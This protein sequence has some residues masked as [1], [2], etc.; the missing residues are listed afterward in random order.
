M[1]DIS[2]FLLKLYFPKYHRVVR[3]NPSR[4]IERFVPKKIRRVANIRLRMLNVSGSGSGIDCIGSRKIRADRNRGVSK[5]AIEVGQRGSPVTGGVEDSIQ[6]HRI[7]GGSREKIHLHC[8][9]D[10]AEIS[11]GS[12][13]AKISTCFFIQNGFDPIGNDGGIRAT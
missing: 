4:T 8:I 3:V 11:T 1:D 12:S 2:A 13:V 6:C 5:R 10:V 7:L 9:F